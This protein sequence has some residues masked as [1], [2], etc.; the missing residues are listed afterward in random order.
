MEPEG[1]RLR[2]EVAE[3]MIQAEAKIVAASKNQESEKR[4]EPHCFLAIVVIHK[5]VVCDPAHGATH[6]KRTDDQS[7][8]HF[9]AHLSE[10]GKEQGSDG[11]KEDLCGK[12]V[13]P[14]ENERASID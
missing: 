3:M 13:E 4:D 1:M 12:R 10:T 5:E 11:E 9:V 6:P 2:A 8:Q 7:P 14:E